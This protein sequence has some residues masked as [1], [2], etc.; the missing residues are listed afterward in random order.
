ML[1]QR[2][3]T[4]ALPDQSDALGRKSPRGLVAYVEEGKVPAGGEGVAS[5]LVVTSFL[6][7]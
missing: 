4:R 1:Q 3:G 2:V 7:D 5:Y 6:D